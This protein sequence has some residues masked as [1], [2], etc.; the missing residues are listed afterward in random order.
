MQ[1]RD[2]G[3]LRRFSVLTIEAPT[4]DQA[5]E[6]LRGIASKYEA[7]HKVQIGEGA[8]VAAVRLAKRYLQDRALPDAAIDLLDETAA[9]KRVEIDGVP[10]NVDQA[11]RRLASL[12]AQAASLAG[13]ADAMS[14]KTRERIEKEMRELEPAV[15]EMRAK[16]DSRRGAIA[17]LASLRGEK[18]RV[19]RP[20]WRTPARSTTSRGSARSSTCSFRT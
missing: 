19:C 9:R 15:S 7:H 17:A 16:L 4:L 20:S 3:L 10:A 11:I 2:P 12:K 6:I 18:R 5:I 13:D 14:V 1:E 8:I